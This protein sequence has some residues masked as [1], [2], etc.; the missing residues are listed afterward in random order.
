[1]RPGG[2]SVGGVGVRP[3]GLRGACAVP[4][5]SCPVSALPV[6]EAWGEAVASAGRGHSWTVSSSR[7][8]FFFAALAL[9]AALIEAFLALADILAGFFR[10]SPMRYPPLT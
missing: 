10:V 9:R 6:V 5:L 3:G 4:P 8:S 7:L 1:M 2:C